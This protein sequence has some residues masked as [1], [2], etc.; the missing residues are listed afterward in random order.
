MF[1]TRGFMSLSKPKQQRSQKTLEKI[2]EA[3]EALLADATFEEIS[4]QAIASHAG[5]SVGNLYN[6]FSNKE[7]LIG[8]LVER[9]HARFAESVMNEL[10][11]FPEDRELS[12]R[13]THLVSVL[14][15]DVNRNASLVKAVAARNLAKRTSRTVTTDQRA[16]EVIDAL[17]NWLMVSKEEIKHHDA[18]EACRFAI[19]S[20][21]FGL[22]YRLIFDTP[23]RLHGPDRYKSQLAEMGLSYLTQP[24]A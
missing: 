11:S 4:M 8:H 20:I 1:L 12:D 21:I 9:M 14:E 10:E 2:T 18:L 13:L 3:C 23:D 19:T 5:I 24:T 6:R 17:L 7:A 16:L 22:Q 15:N